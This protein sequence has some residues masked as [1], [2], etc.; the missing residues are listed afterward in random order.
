MK[1]EHAKCERE[2][3]NKDMVFKRVIQRVHMCTE[4]SGN[5]EKGEEKKNIL[6]TMCVSRCVLC[7]L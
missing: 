3:E 7:F 2:L 6:L 4:R 1:T 5:K